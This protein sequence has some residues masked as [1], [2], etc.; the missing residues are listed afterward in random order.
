MS[1]FNKELNN[2]DKKE[3]SKDITDLIQKIAG[4]LDDEVKEVV[5]KKDKKLNGKKNIEQYVDT[6]GQL[7]SK[8][9]KFYLWASKHKVAIY[10]FS[11]I[12]LTVFII[13]SLGYSIF[14]ISDYGI[15][16]YTEDQILYQD[17]A[18]SYDYTGIH[19][20]YEPQPLQILDT[21]V[22]E[23]G[24]DRFD[25]VA[26]VFNSNK[27]FRVEFD[28]HFVIDGLETRKEHVVFMPS[29]LRP[30][31]ILGIESEGYIGSNNFIISNVSWRRIS[32]HDVSDIDSWLEERLQFQAEDVEFLR[33]G[34]EAKLGTHIIKLNVLN[35]SA[36]SYKSPLFQVG[37][38][39]GDAL[40]GLMPI[41]FD[42]F[43]TLDLKSVDFRSFVNNLSVTEI[44]LYPI[45]D[46]FDEEVYTQR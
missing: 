29:E 23:S 6:T 25:L 12:S 37:L 21:K 11:V 9:L 13:L 33:S 3:T 16:G 2:R 30:I 45:I 4:S 10:R 35:D 42:D 26:E 24:V 5:D 41:Q 18:S 7:S 1:N 15:F 38:Y 20:R 32:R 19:S 36:Y 27:W 31:G 43:Y 17:L 39:Q 34:G 22:I 44:E 28:Y 14:K 46:L 8:N 40:V